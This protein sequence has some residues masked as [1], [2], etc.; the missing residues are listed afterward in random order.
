MSLT[1]SKQ[2]KS[3][4]ERSIKLKDVGQ[5]FKDFKV[6]VAGYFLPNVKVLQATHQHISLVKR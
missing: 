2:G 6:T 1:L 5:V 4:V 3:A